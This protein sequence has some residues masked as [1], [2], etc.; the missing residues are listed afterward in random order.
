MQSI[1]INATRLSRLWIFKL[2]G[3]EVF[4]VRLPKK[5]TPTVSIGIHKGA[6]FDRLKIIVVYL[7]S[8]CV[9]WAFFGMS[10]PV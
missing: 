8:S 2:L 10:E 9:N 3:F 7:T 4:Q 1:S 6:I 5:A